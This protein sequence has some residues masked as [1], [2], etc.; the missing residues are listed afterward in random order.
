MKNIVKSLVA[1]LGIAVFITACK[2]DPPLLTF[3]PST[4]ITLELASRANVAPDVEDSS[5]AG[6]FFRWNNPNMATAL[7][8]VRFITE[9]DVA[10]GN[11]ENAIRSTTFGRFSD[12]VINKTMNAFLLEKG[13]GFRE[14]VNMKARTIASYSNNNDM[15]FSNP[16]NFTFRTYKV[17]PRVPLPATGKLFIVGSATEGGWGT[18]PVPVPRQEF[19][20]LDETTWAGVFQLYG[21]GEYLVIP[22]NGQWQK[23][24]LSDNSIPGIENG[25]EF[26]KELPKN[27]KGPLTDGL[28]KITLDFQRGVFKVEPFT[29]QHGL[30]NQLVMVGNATPGGWANNA[31]NPQKL[32]QLNSA[33]W[34]M[35]RI[36]L[37]AN[38]P[39]LILP[40]P[41]SW[42][43]KYGVP[44]RNLPSARLSGPFKP[45]GQDFRA[46]TE[47]G[48]YRIIMNFVT[49]T[50][51]LTKL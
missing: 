38:E 48:D 39:Y 33:V 14:V 10:D 12:S 29:L 9:V 32:R 28:Y 8:N 5:R 45:E 6:I 15:V 30:P 36:R 37:T 22:V 42:S 7:T 16:V 49:E 24:S 47:T 26:G 43:K 31:N 23:Y 17:P 35:Q 21:G 2:K 19:A 40:E 11:W 25:G 44:D 50:Y 4:G 34:E 3:L 1:V 46:P 13:F 27:F 20:R 41:G 51:Q 18:N